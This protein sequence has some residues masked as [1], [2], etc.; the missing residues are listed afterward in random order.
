MSIPVADGGVKGRRKK[1][2]NSR[3]H[4]RFVGVRQRPSGRWVAEIKDSLQKVRLWLGTFDT[5]DDAAR[6]YDD[7]ARSL[8]GANART[9][10]EPPDAVRCS[11]ENSEPFC[12][13]EACRSE[14]AENGLVGALRAKLFLGSSSKHAAAKGKSLGFPASQHHPVGVKRKTPSTAV[15]PSVITNLPLVNHDLI[16]VAS[17]INLDEG[18]WRNTCYEPQPWSATTASSSAA[19]NQVIDVLSS[20]LDTSLMDS[21]WPLTNEAIEATVVKTATGIWQEQQVLHCDNSW[22]GSGSGGGDQALNGAPNASSWDP[23]IYLNSVL[24]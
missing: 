23:F 20:L 9:N 15:P 2:S 19:K 17:P 18:Q 13:E 3:G 7:A 1:A 14:D 12:F 5:A 11:P 8:R 4:P 10:F 16:R 24:G 6:A 22:G 21:L